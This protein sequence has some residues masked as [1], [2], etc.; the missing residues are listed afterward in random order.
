MKWKKKII[1]KDLL[2]KFEKYTLLVPSFEILNCSLYGSMSVKFED[3]G[4][5]VKNEYEWLKN[6]EIVFILVQNCS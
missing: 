3:L 4:S 6:Y 2:H 1:M 5:R